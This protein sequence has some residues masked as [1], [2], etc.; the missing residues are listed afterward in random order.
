MVNLWT[1]KFNSNIGDVNSLIASPTPYLSQG[2]NLSV[3]DN[4]V[5]GENPLSHEITGL[6]TGVSYSARVQSYTRGTYHGYSNYTLS[7]ESDIPSG[8]PPAIEGVKAYSTLFVD[9]VQ[10]I[11]LGAANIHEIQSVTT[12]ATAISAIQEIIL[13][14]PA[15]SQSTGFFALRF[16]EIQ[17][18]TM[19]AT[20]TISKGSFQLRY[21]Y[22][23]F[24]NS[25]AL[26]E[27]TSA[28]IPYSASA[29]DV[30]LALESLPSGA[31]DDV[32][33]VRSGSGSY[34][35]RF[36]YVWTVSFVGNKVA[37]NVKALQV[38]TDNCSPLISPTSDASVVVETVN[39]NGA[40]GT[41][42]EIQ[43]V[44]VAADAVIAQGQFALEVTHAGVTLSTNCINWNAEAADV[45]AAM[46]SLSN[47]DSVFVERSGDASSASNYGYKYNNFLRWKFIS[48][49]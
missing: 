34:L 31:I 32:E 18:I 37:G 45:E 23:A 29:A 21:S 13:T 7:L 19:T 43:S 47:V 38:V 17:T 6:L 33:V 49:S 9:E 42:T 5:R 22:Y 20:S 28:C 44:V 12:S 3:Y 36:G 40:V 25:M 30:E 24:N 2:T 11:V 15:Y 27:D 48:Y 10:Q 46:E 14:T 1:V 16:P 41:D 35:S 8:P 26:L 4:L 39:P